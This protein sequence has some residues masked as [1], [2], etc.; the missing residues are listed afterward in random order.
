MEQTTP[1]DWDTDLSSSTSSQLILTPTSSLSQQEAENDVA[2]AVAVA[3][4]RANEDDV[5]DQDEEKEPPE[6][7]HDLF[8]WLEKQL[9]S[10]SVNSPTFSTRGEHNTY[11][12][13][14]FETITNAA[15]TDTSIPEHIFTPPLTSVGINFHSW[16]VKGHFCCPC[17]FG[18]PED[19]P[20]L[21][22]D[23]AEGVTKEVFLR[24]IAGALYGDPDLDAGVVGGEEDRP[25]VDNVTYMMTRREGGGHALMGELWVCVRGLRRPE[26]EESDDDD[27]DEDDEEDDESDVNGDL[28]GKE[29][30]RVQAEADKA[31]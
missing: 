23:E 6:I 27:E 31:A 29:G 14:A 19:G 18:E 16:P 5:D 20:E 24:A 21:V 10:F 13:E 12:R 2:V 17:D 25:V 9:P 7:H 15:I 8:A 30:E 26:L 1:N 3:S 11:W 22:I 4:E 28:V